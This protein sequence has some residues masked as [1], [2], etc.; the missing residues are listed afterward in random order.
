MPRSEDVVCNA[1]LIK[2]VWEIRTRDTLQKQY[3]DAVRQEKSALKKINE[4]WQNRMGDKYKPRKRIE[5]TIPVPDAAPPKLRIS[6][7][8]TKSSPEIN[9]PG[10]SV[11]R[12]PLE[13][14]ALVK[15]DK[16]ALLSLL[17]SSQPSGTVWSSSYKFSKLPG[18]G[19]N[20]PEGSD[21]G[22]AWKCLNF[23]PQLNGKAWI[24]QENA[25]MSPNGESSLWEKSPRFVDMGQSLENHMS[26]E[27]ESSWKYKKSGGKKRD[28]VA[29]G[30][31][32]GR[33]ARLKHLEASHHKN[34]EKCS[35]EW[36]ESWKSTK[37]SE[38]GDVCFE[39][40]MVQSEKGNQQGNEDQT[41]SKWE[42][43]WKYLNRQFHS[44]SKSSSKKPK[45]CGWSDAWKIS[46]PIEN[47]DEPTETKS[48]DVM[49]H[50]PLDP[51]VHGVIIP[52]CT[53]EKYKYRSN[54]FREGKNILAEWDK[55]W[56]AAKNISI[57]AS[58]K[59]RK[60]V[61]PKG[62]EKNDE[63][64]KVKESEVD[65]L[66][67]KLQP[68]DRLEVWQNR[69]KPLSEWD[70]PYEWNESWKLPL[71]QPK[72][73][74]WANTAVLNG[75]MV[76][77]PHLKK[78]CLTDWMESWKCSRSRSSFGRP[79]ATEW[80]ES[81]CLGYEL[82]KGREQWMKEIGIEKHQG[83]SNKYEVFSLPKRGM[84]AERQVSIGT[85]DK[86]T[87]APEWKDSSQTVKHQRRTEVARARSNRSQPF[88]E[89]ERGETPVS[90]WSNAWKFTNVT[91]NQ[92][93]SLWDQGWSS[94]ENVRQDRWTREQEF[95]NEEVPHNGPTG[96]RGWGDAWRST[97]RQHRVEG[98]TAGQPP[99]Q[100]QQHKTS[101]LS[102]GWEDSWR[103]SGTQVRQTL[104]DR[105]SMT[106][107][108]DSWE[109]SG[110]NWYE[111]PP[112]ETLL[113][114]S[115]EIVPRRTLHRVPKVGQISRS[116]NTD[117]FNERVPPSQWM[118]S[119]R[120]AKLQRHHNRFTFQNKSHLSVPLH[121]VEDVQE[122]AKTWKFIN[123]LSQQDKSLWDNGWES[124][125]LEK[126]PPAPKYV[127]LTNKAQGKQS[128]WSMSF[129]IC[130]PQPLE[131][132]D[133]PKVFH[134][135]DKV[136]WSRRRCNNDL[137]SHLSSNALSQRLW[138]KSWRFMK[139]ES[140]LFPV[141]SQM[142]NTTSSQSDNSLI[143]SKT[144]KAKKSMY[145]EIEKS[146]PQPKRWSD[147]P[148]LAKTQPR[149]R[150]GPIK[151][152]KGKEEAENISMEW[153]DSW[154]FSNDSISTKVEVVSWSE[155]GNSWKFLLASYPPEKKGRSI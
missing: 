19:S 61:E 107:W 134:H 25:D 89:P 44:V 8:K 28:G 79:S 17:K 18:E 104:R 150:G 5:T 27:W 73:D 60:K 82:R 40:N 30:P 37:P 15:S 38:N 56:E 113:Q 53:A 50:E 46:K 121:Q 26:S 139:L 23:Q 58:V 103:V 123:L 100:R 88:R 9:R 35:S 102:A 68:K 94:T 115:M 105:P 143:V 152:A 95:L 34:E 42:A 155:W 75:P 70:S 141:M 129:K 14:K 71:S 48:M 126:R 64:K 120:V 16:L 110:L 49:D 122:W 41:G 63:P 147:A 10:L 65:G 119:W 36:I 99:R 151:R 133:T 84:R 118:E 77:Q 153:V 130:G 109:F 57:L 66:P 81:S 114:K 108:S 85:K 6:V 47:H 124:F 154:K 69:M 149:A 128:E 39:E 83:K 90:D 24:E 132:D 21:W 51:Y 93:S 12:Q 146:K 20:K 31:K 62:E 7:S 4:E 116:F 140:V 111:C 117:V 106:E 98:A 78:R 96:F 43:S 138:G 112:R 13:K 55:S 74:H 145:S 32:H 142:S 125:E 137:Y 127:P 91:L 33:M 86:Y 131:W 87:F 76:L 2:G 29:N 45:S 22:T 59:P 3:N 80:K 11:G 97:R 92:D 101:L 148:K 144:S 72:K 1:L 52:V 54:Q 136:L 67:K 135:K